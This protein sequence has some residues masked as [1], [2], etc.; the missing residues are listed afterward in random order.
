MPERTIFPIRVR[1]AFAQLQSEGFTVTNIYGDGVIRMARP[2]A[3]GDTL[4]T[5]IGPEGDYRPPSCWEQ[6][7]ADLEREWA[8]VEEA[9]TS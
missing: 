4:Y 2:L 9:F 3:N 5:F 1:M 7:K 6:M 8:E